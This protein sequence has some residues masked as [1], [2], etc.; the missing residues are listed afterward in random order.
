MVAVAV[1]A[2]AV[3]SPGRVRLFARQVHCPWD[4]PGK[5]TGV[6]WHFLLQ[7]NFPTQGSHLRLLRWPAGS[8]TVPSGKPTEQPSRLRTASC[9]NLHIS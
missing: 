9:Y 5:D 4:F 1:V 2:V 6:G 8:L 3:Q 7:G